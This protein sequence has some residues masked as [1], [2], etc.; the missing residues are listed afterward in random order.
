M[1]LTTCHSFQDI[2]LVATCIIIQLTITSGIILDK[3]VPKFLICTLTTSM[4]SFITRS[5]TTYPGR[6]SIK[7]TDQIS[8]LNQLGLDLDSM[9]AHTSSL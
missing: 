2:K 4:A 8:I 3:M 6:F 5:F 7:E 9:E 1:T